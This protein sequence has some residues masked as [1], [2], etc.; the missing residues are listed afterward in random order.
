MRLE[1]HFPECYILNMDKMK[2]KF[3]IGTKMYVFV[4]VTVLF[5]AVTVSALSYYINVSQIDSYFKRLASNSAENYATFVDIDFLRE[6]R[7]LAES[8]EY[9]A[10]RDQCEESEDEAP[11]K[12]YF[13]EHGIW[14]RYDEMREHMRTYQS[15]MQDIEYLYVVAWGFNTD[16]DMYLIDSDD[17][18]LYETGYYEDREE[19]FIGVNPYYNIDPVINHGDW[20]WLCSAYSPVYDEAGNVVCHVGV[21]ISMEDVMAERMQNLSYVVISSLICVIVVLFIGVLLVNKVIVKPLMM[22]TRHIKYF[23]PGDDRDYEEAGVINLDIRNHDEIRDIYDEIRSM[24]IRIVDNLNSIS[25]M[26]KDNEEVSRE[27]FKDALTGV[28][29]KAAYNRKMVEINEAIANGVE[30]FAIVMLDVNGLK[31]MNDEQ[32]HAAGDTYIRGCCR[33]ACETFKHSPVFRIGG[34]EFVAILMGDDYN[35]RNERVRELKEFFAKAYKN[36]KVEPWLRFSCSVGMAE[37]TKGDKSAEIVFRRADKLMY[38]DKLRFK[39]ENGIEADAR[40]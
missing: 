6:L 14:E 35:H 17:V 12:A 1:A 36:E 15:H 16:K 3:N 39:K 40:S 37:Y 18:P 31:V 19:E 13:E 29:N 5:V 10:L 25:D 20:G 30:D 11:I 8:D 9:Q 2:T 23:L 22:I 38:E 24:Q 21:D 7:N 4:I 33:V 26:E 32:G 27:A 34:D 28:G